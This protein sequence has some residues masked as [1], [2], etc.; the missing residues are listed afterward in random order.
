[1]VLEAFQTHAA[2]RKALC[3]TPTVEAAYAIAETFQEAGI[4]AEALDATTPREARRA[5][6]H[7]LHTGETQVVCNCAVLTEGFDEPS[8]ACVIMARPTQSRPFYIQML[9]RG[10]RTYP[11]KQDCVVLDVVGI[12]T[13]HKLETVATLFGVSADAQASAGTP[14]PAGGTPEAPA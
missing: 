2:T 13:R 12:S 6:L 8:I 10:L 3:F 7:R 5:I 14:P 4:A 11:G 1:Q 9:G